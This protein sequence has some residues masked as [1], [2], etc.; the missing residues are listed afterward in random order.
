MGVAVS[1]VVV[2]GR[3]DISDKALSFREK[4]VFLL[5][6]VHVP[7]AGKASSSWG[8]FAHWSLL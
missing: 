7:W 1:V 2:E 8:F 6:G 5:P 4:N 3:E